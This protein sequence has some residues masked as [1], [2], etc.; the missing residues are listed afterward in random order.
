[1]FLKKIKN[2]VLSFFSNLV[3]IAKSFLGRLDYNKIKIILGKTR[4]FLQFIGIKTKSLFVASVQ[5]LQRFFSYFNLREKIIMAVLALVI[6]IAG[7]LWHN[8]EYAKRTML[9]PDYGGTYTEGIL[10][11]KANDIQQIKDKLTRIGLAQFDNE[12]RIQPALAE[13]W[14]IKD[15]G[16]TYLFRLRP[17]VHAQDITDTLKNQKNEWGDAEIKTPDDHTLEIKLPSAFSPFLASL[18]KPIFPYGPYT[19]TKED[20]NEFRFKARHDF[21]LSRPYLDN[22]ILKTYSKEED[23]A[24]AFQNGELDGLA[25][26]DNQKISH[27]YQIYEMPLSRWLV[28]FFNLKR[29]VLK[30]KN[31]R[32]K[33]ANNEK[34]DKNIELVLVTSD[35]QDYVARAEEIRAKWEP[36]GA[37]VNIISR[38]AVTLQ[39]ETIPRRDY[40][41]LLYGLDYGADPDSYPFWHSSQINENGLNLSNF[42]NVDVDKILEEARQTTDSSKRKEFYDQFQKKFDDERPAIF[43]E[44]IKWKYLVSGKIKGISNH[45]GV[46]PADRY[47]EVWKW[48]VKEKRVK[49]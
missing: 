26:Y 14:E 7:F 6:I 25:S 40:D 23:L 9:A 31:I 47:N 10:A 39:K 37:K 41:L 36:L 48:W 18:T 49:K 45:P 15:D 30:D 24:N 13:N 35:K 5:I 46:N 34:L 33:L 11:S 2:R 12:N 44:Q 19:L 32:N 3:V 1:M 29:D 43:L 22:I 16:K 8:D 28:L 21:Y 42:A 17:S 38:D 27:K 4:D 20:K